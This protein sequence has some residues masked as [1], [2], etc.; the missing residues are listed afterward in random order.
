MKYFSVFSL[1][2][3]LPLV[4]ACPAKNTPRQTHEGKRKEWTAPTTPTDNSVAAS[5]FNAYNLRAGY[6]ALK[7]D[8]NVLLR[9]VL[10]PLSA[11]VLNSNFIGKPEFRTAR[12][13]QMIQ[14]F[15]SAFLRILESKDGG[16]EFAAIKNN[17]YRTMFAGCSQD[18]K[19]G[20]INADLFS[21]DTRHTRI[22]TL[23][24]RELDSLLETSLKASGTAKDCIAND[25]AC[26]TAV[27]ERYRM[28][29]MGVYKRN[30]YEDKEFAFAY[31]KYARVFAELLEVGSMKTSYLAEVHGQIFDILI[32]KYQPKDLKDPEFREFVENFNPWKYSVKTA[33]LFQ[34]GSR[35]MFGY[36]T[37]CCLYQD[38]ARTKLSPAV[39]TAIA[40]SQ[41]PKKEKDSFL[42]MVIE[43]KNEHGTRLFEN[44]GI[45]ELAE[46]I[47]QQDP[48]FFNEFFFVV[49]RL[50]RGHL[51][52]SEVEMVLANSNP[53]R[54]QKELPKTITAYVK[55]QLA[56][57]LL[58]TN[59]FFRDKI[60]NSGLAS[61][62]VFE[63][64][65]TR[66]RELTSRWH[67]MQAQ[68]DLLDRMLG[69]YFKGTFV[70][71][72]YYDAT[73]LIKSV[74][75]NIHY[76]AVDNLMIVMQYFL[77][78]M[79]GKIVVNSFWGSFEID[80]DTILDAFF[81]G[82]I[83]SPWFR[84]GKDPEMLTRPMLL[85]S[86]EYMLSTETLNTF[87][88]P[89]SN[90]SD[91]A[92]FF[93]MVFT[94]YL[95]DN[96]DGLRTSIANYRRETWGDPRSS[97]MNEVCNY[98]LGN[99]RPETREIN[100]LELNRY[101]Y[102]G[103]GENGAYAVLGNLVTKSAS[104]I[105]DIRD[106]VEFRM[107][108][109]EV[110]LK[111][112]EHDLIR[113]GKIQKA[114][115]DHADT[116]RLRANIQELE[117]MKAELAGLFV[118][119]HAKYFNCMLTVREVERRRA[120]RL[121]QEERAYLGHIYD[122]MKPLSAIQDDAQLSAKVA[123][124]N[125]ALAQDAKKYLSDSGLEYDFDRVLD[126][127]SFKMSQYN[128]IMR[129]RKRIQDDIFF[130]TPTPAETD[131]LDRDPRQHL[132]PRPVRVYLPAGLNREEM[133]HK[134]TAITINLRDS[135]EDFISQGMVALNGKSGAFLDWRTQ[136]TGASTA[137]RK[138]VETLSEFFMLGP[139]SKGQAGQFWQISKE[140]VVNSFIKVTALDAMDDFD[141]M[142]AKDF[143]VDGIQ[144]KGFF[145]GKLFE[146]DFVTRL[147]L[148]YDLMKTVYTAGG[149]HI[150]KG[151]VAEALEFAQQINNLQ[152]F[153]F[154]PARIKLKNGVKVS[155][156]KKEDKLEAGETCE[157]Q[158]ELAVREVYGERAH[159][160]LNRVGEIFGYLKQLDAGAADAAAL[161]PR[162]ARAFY[163][164]GTTAV[165]WQVRGFKNLIDT[166]KME[167]LSAL[168]KD[169]ANRTGNFY[170]TRE[171]VKVP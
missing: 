139:V 129:M 14:V 37:S 165:P 111:I 102:A 67:A 45:K 24:A 163:I 104:I 79:K 52:T 80:A 149:I 153:I 97:A 43:I 128:L 98:E 35:V 115:D 164:N 2:L 75:R 101:T 41:D 143:G 105:S 159:L 26:R 61:S 82:N 85:Y 171:K 39:T 54:V 99:T 5:D 3:I 19:T 84:F 25:E 95:D 94:K 8:T 63:A 12:L 22:M 146:K 121:Y 58:Q 42:A 20:C 10:Q 132:K 118:Q 11:F 161:D 29:A 127:R 167:D 31:L 142:N 15:N 6:A 100:L 131:S 33:D 154:E 78:K 151:A 106:K 34:R 16:P 158:I 137:P 36:A 91:R 90:G 55:I 133:V 103:L 155:G 50:Y 124:V 120:N 51:N 49:D 62:E 96:F 136:L 141:L 59:I 68:I 57:M 107:A 73:R 28:L 27:E 125:N 109:T 30:R 110:M 74:N 122:V 1:I 18:L 114:G 168:V 66:S 60:Y 130:R 46:Q 71:T 65:V 108:Y 87:K 119:N 113:S 123:E 72:E 138:Y 69:S 92:R 156:C 112:L 81:D 40:K 126:G 116:A 53:V 13:T 144:A 47:I 70:S 76:V 9:S 77:A 7:G 134:G 170:K 32:A 152:T 23:L 83:P 38:D 93:D 135:R 162:L 48:R 145:E 44:L 17:Y 166:Q 150:E 56:Y 88:E 157:Q 64:S 169:F 86:F 21:R 147:P 160:R 148:F 117:Q 140:E 89:S 4:T